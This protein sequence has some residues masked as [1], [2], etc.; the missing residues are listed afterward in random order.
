MRSTECDRS[1]RQ[2]TAPTHCNL[3]SWRSS[4]GFNRREAQRD[5]KELCNGDTGIRNQ[6][7]LGPSLVQGQRARIQWDRFRRGHVHCEPA[8]MDVKQVNAGILR[9]EQSTS[10]W[11]QLLADYIVKTLSSRV[12]VRLIC[13]D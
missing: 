10:G 13:H 12:C 8:C 2:E 6:E 1:S 5:L 11:I 7:H 3:R 4:R 9:N